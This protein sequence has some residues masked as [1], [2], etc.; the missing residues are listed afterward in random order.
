MSADGLVLYFS[1]DRTGGAGKLDLYRATRPTNGS[2]TVDTPGPFTAVNTADAESDNVFSSD[3]LTLYFAS[4]RAGGKG[5]A[6]I[7]KA[8]RTSKSSAFGAP[9]NVTEL[10]TTSDDA[11]SWISDDGCRIYVTRGSAGSYSIYAATKPK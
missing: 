9:T 5:G 11:P 3:E 4:D 7:W 1:S 6:D 8:T 10:N 2:F